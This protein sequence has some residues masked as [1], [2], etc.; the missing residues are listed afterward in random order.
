MA[1]PQQWKLLP[2]E[3]VELQIGQIDLLLAMYPEEI[4]LDENSQ[5]I[6]DIFRGTDN[7][8]AKAVV[9]VTPSIPVNLDLPITISEESLN[10]QT[11]RLDLGVPFV[12]E[13]NHAPLD[14]PEVKVRVQQPNWMSRAATA[15]LTSELPQDEDLL[16]TIEHI[17][18]AAVAYLVEAQKKELETND[19]TEEAG[20][21]VRVWFYFPSISTRSKRDDFIIHAPSYQLTGFLYAGKPGLLCVEGGSQSIDDYMKFIKTESWGDIPA[22]HK[23]VSERHR[24]KCEKRVFPDMTEITDTVGERRGQRAN[25]GDMKAIE[26]WLVERGLGDAFTK[27]LM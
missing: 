22:H 1:D 21:L 4:V 10:P 19:I 23:K 27:V 8:R 17:R 13:G 25:R 24:E 7:D 14:P 6:L 9:K 16:G 12:Y 5:Q 3:L 2:P 18:E 11:L 20:P 26:E 15:Q